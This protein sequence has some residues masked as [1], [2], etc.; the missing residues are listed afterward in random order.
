MNSHMCSVVL[1]VVVPPMKH[2]LCPVPL[3]ELFPSITFGAIVV[4]CALQTT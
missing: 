1:T 3:M 4:E 2:V